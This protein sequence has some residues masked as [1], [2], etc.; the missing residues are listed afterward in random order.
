MLI[1][2]GVAPSMLTAKGYGSTMPKASNE[3]AEGRY[4]N[5]RIEYTVGQ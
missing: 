5:R 3:T 2:E 1:E 4:Q